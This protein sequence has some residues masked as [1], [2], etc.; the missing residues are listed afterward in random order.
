MDHNKRNKNRYP[1]E[2]SEHN[3]V[4][5][6]RSY[7]KTKKEYEL[8]ECFLAL[9]QKIVAIV[10]LGFI[11]YI[12]AVGIISWMLFGGIL[13]QTLITL[14]TVSILTIRF[15]KTLRKRLTLKRKLK[16][17]CEKSHY[18]LSFERPFLK[19]L[20]WSSDQSD[21]TIT[22]RH[23]IFYVHL[24][25]APTYRCLL[26]FDSASE[27][28]IVKP[29][30]KNKFSVIFDFKT[31]VKKLSLDFSDAREYDGKVTKRIILVNPVCNEM[32]YKV[33]D[34]STSQTGNGGEHFGYQ[35]FTAT[36]FI[37]Y[38]SRFENDIYENSKASH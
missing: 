12:I 38:L 15:T 19:S 27:I 22:T 16:K 9:M 25:P 5:L 4:P 32:H 10:F 20:K 8:W 30:L 34:V 21:I 31:K 11:F 18:D 26:Y 3:P 2:I 36:G 35:I 24:L 17:A 29:P 23:A 33:S 14:A 6:H 37:N 1:A 7:G 13:V 28:R